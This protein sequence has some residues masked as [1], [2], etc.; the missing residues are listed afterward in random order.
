MQIVQSRADLP[1]DLDKLKAYSWDLS[2]AY[3]QLTEKYRKLL[4]S[5]YGR[6]SEKIADPAQLEAIQMELDALLE[7]SAAVQQQREQI[8]AETVEVTSHRRR[9]KHPGRN[10]IPE[11]LIT[12]KTLDIP[13][14]EKI[15]GCCGEPMEVIDTKKHVVVER[16]PARY[17]ATRYL[18][19]VYG[20]SRCKDTVHVA[21]PVVLPI[22]KGLAG[23]QLLLFVILSKYQYHLPLYR[24]QRQIFH[25]SSIWFTRS[26]LASWVRQLCGLLERIHQGLLDAY[27]LSRIKHADESPLQVMYDGHY[28]E[29]WMWVGLS[30]DGRTAVF[31]YNRHRSGKAALKLLAG[32]GA[33]DF[34]MVDDC[35]SYP[36]AIRELRLVDMRC[37]VHIRRKFV[38]ALKAGAQ[39]VF[40][41]R[42]LIKIGQLYRIERLA[43]KGKC[44]VD[45][46]TELRQKYS[47]CVMEQ[48]K[49]MLL[50]PGF[51]VLPSLLT[52]LAINYFLRNWEQ[53]CVFLQS[54]ELPIDNSPNERIIRSFAI[55]RNNWMQCGS[56]DG[57]R[58]MATLYSIL[59]TCKLNAIDANEYLADVFM[60][61]PIRPEGVDISDLLPVE[62]YKRKYGKMP[63]TVS[64]YPSK[65]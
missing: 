39:A 2:L 10:V 63:E 11:E 64:L 31:L 56:E 14:E 30:G 26:T 53:A 29:C 25:E 36:K 47:R 50:D 60:R 23:P 49:A 41:K 45:R 46:R 3:Q 32:S 54:G 40:N 12:E 24:I 52:G 51:K 19:P 16:I 42:I 65:N 59:T 1:Q 62:W 8:E 43:T 34:L 15:C 7:Q 22:A 6:S 61:L 57:A 55:G 33:G 5:M 9:R 35:P 48:I 27:R 17:E 21:E 58:R 28:H 4:G 20:C 13:Q 44:S 18:R 38:E 37:M